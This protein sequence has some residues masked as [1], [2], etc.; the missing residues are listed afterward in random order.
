[1]KALAGQLVAVSVSDAPDRLRLGF[2]Q[3]EID[4]ALLSTCIALVRAGAEVA[5]A[6]NLDPRGYTYKI[7]RHLAGAYAA[8]SVTPFKH[9][10]PEPVARATRFED[11]R[12]TLNE[13]RGVAR[14]SIARG[15]IFVPARPRGNDIRLGEEVLKNEQQLAAWFA[16]EPPRPETEGFSLA[17]RMVSVCADA[18]VIMGGKM[19]IL[20]DCAD[21][22]DGAIPGVVEEA[23]MTLEE[24]KP[25][26]VLGAFGGAARDIA[27]ALGI[28][29]TS[30]KVPRGEQPKSYSESLSRVAHL[31]SRIP[32]DLRDTLA[33]IADDD[34][35]EQNGLRI[36]TVLERWL[37]AATEKSKLGHPS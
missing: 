26:I 37:S 22:Y 15:E 2:P 7:F 6:G 14:T 3:R 34:R 23:I 17:R 28:M 20:S 5:Y 16:T 25:L 10:I 35:A 11:L 31:A 13:A 21:A 12:A 8:S 9:F 30:F 27:I 18:R 32:S 24:N 1:M 33:L 19:G 4:R 36:V 29:D